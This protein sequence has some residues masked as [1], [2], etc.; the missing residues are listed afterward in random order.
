LAS[1]PATTQHQI[2]FPNSILKE[3]RFKTDEFKPEQ[4]PDLKIEEEKIIK[5]VRD[6]NL[7]N[8]SLEIPPSVKLITATSVL[9]AYSMSL[10]ISVLIAIFANMSIAINILVILYCVVTIVCLSG[11]LGITTYLKKR[12]FLLLTQL[13]IKSNKDY[14][15]A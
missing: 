5:V 7:I 3:T 2:V 9:A 15:E 8:Y 6:C 11:F 4:Y 1:R 14:F 13:I 12:R 10:F